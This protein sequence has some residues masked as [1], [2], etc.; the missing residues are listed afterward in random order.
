MVAPKRSCN[1]ANLTR[2]NGAKDAAS[3]HLPGRIPF[4]DDCTYKKVAARFV[5]GKVI[6]TTTITHEFTCDRFRVTSGNDIVPLF[7]L[8]DHDRAM[9][10]SADTK[11]APSADQSIIALANRVG[12]ATSAEDPSA[13]TSLDNDNTEAPATVM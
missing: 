12:K 6:K 11:R 8:S 2:K 13:S 10:I 9:V 4:G 5:A 3:H 7:I 1:L